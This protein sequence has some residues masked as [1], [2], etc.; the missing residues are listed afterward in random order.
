M[1]Q[2]KF[3]PISQETQ[4]PGTDYNIQIGVIQN[5][6]RSWGVKISLGGKIVTA[7]RIKKLIDVEIVGIIRDT[8]GKKVALDTFDL[9]TTMSSLLREVYEKLKNK[10]KSETTQTQAP[11]PAPQPA[12][13]QTP[14]PSSPPVVSQAPRPQAPAPSP[15]QPAQEE[16]TVPDL[17]LADAKPLIS[18]QP[19]DFWSSYSS[20]ETSTEV[21]NEPEPA[22]PA[23][24]VPAQAP[25]APQPEVAHTPTGASDLDDALSVL[26][27]NCPSCGEEV[28]SDLENCPYCGSKL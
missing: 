26:G 17:H 24:S 25:P 2:I 6:T 18:K 12:P 10:Q 22:Q 4:I 1:V 11:Q 14:R 15:A 28:D 21:Y 16:S 19:D 27:I 8:I 20:V 7:K 3:A 5:D 9:G 23:Y 13:Q